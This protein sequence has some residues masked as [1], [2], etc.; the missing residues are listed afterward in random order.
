MIS[1]CWAPRESYCWKKIKNILTNLSSIW[2]NASLKWHQ[3]YNNQ[4]FFWQNMMYFDPSSNTVN[5]FEPKFKII[6]RRQ[7]KSRS[8]ILYIKPITCYL[9]KKSEKPERCF[10]NKKFGW[11][12]KHGR[13]SPTR[14]GGVLCK[15]IL[16]AITKI[17]HLF[18]MK[19]S[20]LVNEQTQRKGKELLPKL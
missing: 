14:Y 11:Y 20:V 5:I 6:S 16:Y 18:N 12:V 9:V 19:A 3:N 15:K 8:K 1:A 7:K 13:A 10:K 17:K 4:S 2:S